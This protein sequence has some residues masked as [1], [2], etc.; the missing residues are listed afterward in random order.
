[1]GEEGGSESS[2][3]K[4]LPFHFPRPYLRFAKDKAAAGL[5][6]ECKGKVVEGHAEHMINHIGKGGRTRLLEQMRHTPAE[7]NVKLEALI[8]AL[9]R[10]ASWLSMYETMA[11][12]CG[13][14]KLLPCH[15]RRPMVESHSSDKALARIRWAQ[16]G[17]QVDGFLK[18]LQHYNAQNRE[19]TLWSRYVA[20]ALADSKCK[21]L[22]KQL[23]QGTSWL[24]MYHATDKACKDLSAESAG[25]AQAAK[26]STQGNLEIAAAEDVLWAARENPDLVGLDLTLA[27]D[28]LLTPCSSEAT[29]SFVG[30]QNLGNTSFANATVQIFMHVSAFRRWIRE[31]EHEPKVHSNLSTK[32]QRALLKVLRLY[33]SRKWSVIVP[34][35]VLDCIFDSR[36]RHGMI[37][38]M[39][40]HIMD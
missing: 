40:R 8:A 21:E 22:V 6:W 14:E 19:A 13:E 15:F 27:A 30:F 28:Q 24:N 5:Y 18:A 37:A 29:N 36:G 23:L 9:E 16:R 7:T 3:R 10:G 20:K 4:P 25:E 39:Q 17:K 34:I 38:G 26:G 31:M 12:A 1:M 2:K 35:E 32:L 11:E 33:S